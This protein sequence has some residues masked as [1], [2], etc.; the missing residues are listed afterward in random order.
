MYSQKEDGH[1]IRQVV[2]GLDFSIC[3]NVM[4]MR[5]KHMVHTSK[6]RIRSNEKQ[7]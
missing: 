6:Q 3:E 7:I 5:G 2:Y 4:C 1:K